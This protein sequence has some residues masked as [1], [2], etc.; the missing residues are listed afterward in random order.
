MNQILVAGGSGIIGS[1]LK[2]TYRT[3]YFTFFSSKDCDLISDNSIKDF[4]TN[5]KQFDILIFLVGLAH[6]KGKKSDLNEFNNLNY[7]ALVNLLSYLISTD[8]MPEKII[9][10]STISVYGEKYHQNIYNEQMVPNPI[11]PYAKTKLEAEQYLSNNYF[12]ESWILR[13]APVYSSRFFLN[14][15]RRTK[16]GSLFYRVGNGSNKLSLCNIKNIRSVIEGIINNIIPAGI[17]NISDNKSYNY[18]DLLR[19]QNASFILRIP[20][21]IVKFLYYFGKLFENLFLQENSTKL[22]TNN[23]YPNNKITAFIELP[24]TLNDIKLDDRENS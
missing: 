16:I 6:K 20:K 12:N 17:Y 15:D 9:F 10:A 2:Q 22:M 3:K 23:I 11:S 7:Q 5:S 24:Y 19:K 14:I 8:N 18:N 13:F 4:F 1:Y 21:L